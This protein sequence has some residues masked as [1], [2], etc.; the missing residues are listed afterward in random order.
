MAEVSVLACV[1]CEAKV[2]ELYMLHNC[3]GIEFD[4]CPVL[5]LK[6]CLKVPRTLGEGGGR[7]AE[8]LQVQV[9]SIIV[10]LY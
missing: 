10:E 9:T 8:H 7:L 4:H 3:K 5:R 1:F 2:G 6:F